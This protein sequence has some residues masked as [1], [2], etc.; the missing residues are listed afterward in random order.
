VVRE[1][2]E[3]LLDPADPTLRAYNTL[4]WN[5]NCQA[6]SRFH[7]LTTPQQRE[8]ARV[9]LT[10]YAKDSQALMATAP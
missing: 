8:R 10:R 1:W 4:R 2:L 9:R 5:M 7:A 3:K 6:S